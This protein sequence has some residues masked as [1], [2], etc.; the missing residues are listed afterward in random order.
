[1]ANWSN[2]ILAGLDRALQGVR[3]SS[4]VAVTA[5]PR[6][7]RRGP[8]IAHAYEVGPAFGLAA[9]GSREGCRFE[10]RR[11]AIE[12]GVDEPLDLDHPDIAAL[13]WTIK[14]ANRKQAQGDEPATRRARILDPGIQTLSGRNLRVELARPDRAPMPA[15][16]RDSE[17]IR[18]LGLATTDAAGTLIVFAAEGRRARDRDVWF[19]DD[20][21]GW[22]RAELL[23][24]AGPRVLAAR[25]APA[26]FVAT[27]DPFTFANTLPSE[28]IDPDQLAPGDLTKKAIA[29]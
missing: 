19:D 14:V 1:M 2:S 25:I 9:I 28:R 15:A 7:A 22:V 20:C 29:P 23:L 3:T 24:R 17:G 6:V 21:D 11:R 13:T 16:L 4:A 12:T 5:R 27:R 10:L 26:W 8:A 18:S